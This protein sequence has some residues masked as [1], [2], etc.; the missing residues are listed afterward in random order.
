M[1]NFLLAFGICL[2]LLS[3]CNFPSKPTQVDPADLVATKVAQTLIAASG[4]TTSQLTQPI[5]TNALPTLES[6]PSSTPT[7]TIT[8]TTTPTPADPK[9]SLGSPAYTNTFTS[10]SDFDLPYS[11][12]AVNLT[13]HDGGLDFLSL[14]IDYGLRYQL[15][16]PKPQN[17]YLEGVFQNIRCVG[18]DHYGLVARAPNYSDGFGYYISFSCD[19]KYKLEKWDAGGL[20]TIQDWT[21][22]A[23]IHNG[24]GQI[25]QLGVL[26]KG[27]EIKIYANGT[28][29]KELA[30]S[31]YTN[32]GHYGIFGGAINSADFNFVVTEI[33]HW[34][35]P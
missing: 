3:S 21:A 12:D 26:M 31:S 20:N 22:D 2:F 34:N 28:L 32:G 23:H 10:G 9:L 7:Q 27:N 15:T 1:K 18:L 29:I 16:Y 13:V 30:D 11:D 35:L 14:G 6:L 25:N 19:G 17:F 8:P 24:Q 4:T 33:S 5:P